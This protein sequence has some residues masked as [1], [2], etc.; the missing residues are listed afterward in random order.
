MVEHK[1]LSIFKGKRVLVTGDT[2]FKG[3]WLCLWLHELGANVLGV[4]LPPKN[5]TDHFNVI[6]LDKI[7]HH[8][9]LDIRKIEQLQKIFLKFQPEFLFHLAAQA[10]VRLSYEDPKLT[11]DTNIGGSVNLL[12]CA[13]MTPSLRAMV[14]VTSDK[15][16]KN[17]EWLWG[18]RENDELG[19]I[20]PYSTSKAAAELVFSSY[21]DCYW[22]TRPGF[23]AASVRAGNVIGGGDWSQDRIVPDCIKAL[24]NKQPIMIRNPLATRPWQHVLD[25]LFGYLLLA[26]NL[27]IKPSD[28]SGS[29][30]FGPDDESFRTVRDLAEQIIS[31]WGEGKL[32]KI[33]QDNAPHE[34]NMLHLNC[35]KAKRFLGWHPQWDFRR[36]VLETVKWYK[37]YNE[38]KDGLSA[39]TQQMESYME[40]MNDSR[41]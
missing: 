26:A 22:R 4:A 33:A 13:R 30:N 20:D 38:G 5:E 36:G 14:Y 41:C 18:Y 8:V 15:C 17:K 39:S 35:D 27:Y 40:A 32:N 12:E 1:L 19:G 23:G 29:W 11:F 6:G 31:Y 21:L 34:A 2:G 9:D 24:R 25:P 7:V 37:E 16:Y 28:Y 3:S 10:L